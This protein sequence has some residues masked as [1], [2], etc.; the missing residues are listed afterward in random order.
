[1]AEEITEERAEELL[2][3]FAD[4]KLTIPAFF[5]KVIEADD[6]SKMGNLDVIELG[7]PDLPVRTS[8]G[9]ELFCRDICRDEVFADY[10]KKKAEIDTSTSLSKDGVLLK[11]LVTKKSELADLTPKKKENK[12]YFKKK[13]E[14]TQQ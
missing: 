2:R 13:G 5:A 11:L 9:L 6:T 1:M 12:G 7:T 4:E 3:G 14:E 10:W 8:K